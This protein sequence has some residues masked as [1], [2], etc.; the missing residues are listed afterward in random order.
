MHE[1][2][3]GRNDEDFSIDLTGYAP[4]VDLRPEPLA[5]DGEPSFSAAIAVGHG[6]R[7]PTCGGAGNLDMEDM[8]GGVDHFSCTSC[9]LLFQ[10]AR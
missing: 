4:V 9:G 6:D 2:I 1:P 3:G 10:T 8:V 5:R 7:C